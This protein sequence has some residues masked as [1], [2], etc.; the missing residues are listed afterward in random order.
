M[1]GTEIIWNYKLYYYVD[2]RD[3]RSIAIDTNI[4]VLEKVVCRPSYTD[5]DV[6]VRIDLLDR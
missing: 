1:K 4:R 6:Y 5:I 2:A 3:V